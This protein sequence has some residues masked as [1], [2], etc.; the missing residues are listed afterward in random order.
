VYQYLLG[1]SQAPAPRFYGAS[2]GGPAGDGWL[3]LGYLDRG[4]RLRDSKELA[5][6]DQSA[7][8]IGR[9]HAA[10]EALSS[11]PRLSFLNAY[12][13]DYYSGW[14]QRTAEYAGALHRDFPWLGDVCRR[15]EATL[16]P[17]LDAP[18]TVIHGEYYPKNLLIHDGTVY[19]VDWESAALG[20]G[21]ID[22]ATLTDHCDPEIVRHCEFAYRQARW[23][24]GAPAGFT[25]TMD[26]ARLYVHFRWLGDEPGR[27]GRR[28]FWRYEEVRALGERLGLL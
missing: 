25:R 12:D 21:E 8:W 20:P 5:A 23:S 22:L 19:P 9:F 11:S 10:H 2:T 28:R 27:K 15:F 6:W 16:A 18:R 7:C 26:L 4:V 1:P 14:A 13:A 3:I 17:L 24:E